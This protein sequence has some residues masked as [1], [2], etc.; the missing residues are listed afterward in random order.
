VT[1]RGASRLPLVEAVE[2]A[3]AGGVDW[4][5]V[6]ER[7]LQ[8]RQLLAHVEAVAA[9]ARRGA[10]ARGGE[11]VVL[12]NRRTDLVLALGLD[13]VHLGFDGMEPATARAL[14]GGA[15]RIGVSTH[16]PAEAVAAEA[17]GASYV[18]LAPIFS[19][20]SKAAARPP[21]GLAALRAARAAG[22]R[23]VFAQ[24]GVGAENAAALWQAGAAGLAVTG[25]LLGAA[26]PGAAAARLRR[27]L[28]E[29][30]KA[31]HA[32]P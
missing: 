14:L 12:V 9:A 30:A 6:R 31:A 18:H 15:A 1:D 10:A 3:V 22:A 23:A 28:D 26:D 13:G 11:L 32:A 5:Q 27:A 20:R 4:V 17:A 7:V 8:G 24:G 2:A 16:T 19:P 29:A 25:A 21:L